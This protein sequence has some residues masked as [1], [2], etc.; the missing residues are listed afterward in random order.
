MRF[1]HVSSQMRRVSCTRVA[2]IAVGVL[3]VLARASDAVAQEPASG[4]APNPPPGTAPNPPADVP[5]VSTRNT[6]ENEARIQPPPPEAAPAAKTF[7]DSVESKKAIYISGDIAFTRSM[8][9]AFKNDLGFD[10]TGANGVLYGL[11]GGL[12]LGDWRFGAR[13]RVH[14]TT[15]FTLWSVAASVGYGLPWRPLSP[16]F[17][18]HLGYVFDQSVQAGAFRSSLPVGNVLPPNV[19]L[20]GALL[21]IDVNASYWLT[22]FLRLGCFAGVDAMVLHRSRV[23]QPQSLFG[24]TPEL[25]DNPLYA[26]SGTGIGLNVNAGLRGAFDIGF[27]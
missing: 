3:V 1:M 22:K 11:A 24:P 4:T 16:V 19:D 12:R 15:E 13:W 20:R 26:D 18:A 9:G 17:S 6:P 21:G 5:S 27:K 8:L 25:A 14:D 7:D 10:R 2:L 23:G